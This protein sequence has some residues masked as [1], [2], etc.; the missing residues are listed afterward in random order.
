VIIIRQIIKIALFIF[1]LPINLM[2]HAI[3]YR[4]ININYRRIGHLVSEY[5]S[6]LNIFKEDNKYIYFC[7]D[8]KQCANKFLLELISEKYRVYRCKLIIIILESMTRWT[9]LSI[10]DVSE[11]IQANCTAATYPLLL[12]NSINKEYKNKLIKKYE[13]ERSKLLNI[14]FKKIPDWYVCVHYRSN[15]DK[16]PDGKIQEFRNSSLS[17]LKSAINYINNCGGSVILM[18]SNNRSEQVV[19]SNFYDYPNS[20]FKSDKND[21]LL[22][23]GCKFFLGSTS[24]LLQVATFFDI[25]SAVTNCTPL[26][27]S[28]FHRNDIYIY[29][30]YFDN[31]SKVLLGYNELLSL[32]LVENRSTWQNIENISL[33]EN[34]EKEIESLVVL[35]NNTLD[36]NFGIKNKKYGYSKLNKKYYGYN[37]EAKVDPSFDLQKIK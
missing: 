8:E 10:I 23:S 27:I 9:N 19:F 14:F 5:D 26:S 3:G 2:H 25:P 12:N 15:D 34:T 31:T 30:H 16:Y 36:R 21:I 28:P 22:I 35:M 17:N 18:G 33:I 1:L 7:I 6:I 32:G 37:S 29:K 11:F 24:G 20:I 13:S 4:L